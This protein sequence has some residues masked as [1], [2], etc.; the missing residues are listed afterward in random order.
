MNP[1]DPDHRLPHS[2]PVEMDLKRQLELARFDRA[3]EVAE[4][5]AQHR[6]L[7][8]TVELARMNHII[9]GKT[10]EPWRQESVTLTL[11]SGRKETLALIVEPT[12]IA[13]EKLHRA[14]ELAAQGAPVDAAVD[15]YVDLVL[16]HV[17]IDANRR[18]AALASHYFLKRYDVS[19]SGVALHEIGLGDLREEGLIEQFRRTV[20]QMV[21][22]AE[23]RKTD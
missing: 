9:T 7:L 17:F 2:L 1:L 13:R 5:L 8:T 16:A 11:P 20:H 19:I 4:S 21:K 22:F 12:L 18:T 14:T 6:A 10:I 23:K 3:L 15:I